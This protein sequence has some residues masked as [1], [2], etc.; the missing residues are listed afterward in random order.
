[1]FAGIE[2]LIANISTTYHRGYMMSDQGI[3]MLCMIDVFI[4]PTQDAQKTILSC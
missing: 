1:M 4:N 2:I 3:V